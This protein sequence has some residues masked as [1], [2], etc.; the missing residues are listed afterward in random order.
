MAAWNT[1]NQSSSS[2]LAEKEKV[3]ILGLLKLKNVERRQYIDDLKKWIDTSLRLFEEIDKTTDDS[4]REFL[5][6]LG[7]DFNDFNNE[8][9]NYCKEG[10]HQILLLMSIIPQK[11]K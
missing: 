4:Q 3:W 11:M 7:I 10:N 6:I 9:E 5:D 2:L 1:I 8:V